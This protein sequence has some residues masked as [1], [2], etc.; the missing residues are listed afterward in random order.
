MASTKERRVIE[1]DLANVEF[2]TSED[3]EVRNTFFLLPGF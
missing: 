1:E 3:V 2:E